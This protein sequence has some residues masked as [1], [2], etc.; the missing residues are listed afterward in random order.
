MLQNDP[1][2]MS[3]VFSVILAL[4]FI[5]CISGNVIIL[6]LIHKR[7]VFGDSC[8]SRLLIR[9]LAIVDLFA[10]LDCLTCAIGYIDIELIAGVDILCKIE[11]LRQWL[12]KLYGHF[13]FLLLS[14]SR[15]YVITKPQNANIT[16]TRR[17][18]ILAISFYGSG[19]LI[20]GLY[21][22]WFSNFK[23]K[24]A[25]DGGSCIPGDAIFKKVGLAI[26]FANMFAIVFT[27]IRA[28][29][30]Y[31]SRA[32][33]RPE[34]PNMPRNPPSNHLTK[35]ITKAILLIVL[36]YILSSVPFV[37]MIG[38][39]EGFA[40]VWVPI[41]ALRVGRVLF[42]LNS[43]NNAVIFFLTN[44]RFR[45]CSV[46]LFRKRAQPNRGNAKVVQNTRL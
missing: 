9:N 19:V 11:G 13:S 37:A 38:I 21:L 43:A 20:T 14:V 33:L 46:N 18:C 2:E 17:R 42:T 35:A 41:N 26:G 44:R 36:Y 22:F 10:S 4:I 40:E 30:A 28:W 3:Y 6:V 39:S 31:R 8:Q 27:N 23:T 24:I 34:P 7:E 32:Q 15:F 5:L 25:P 16:F 45:E 29:M 1:S 12:T